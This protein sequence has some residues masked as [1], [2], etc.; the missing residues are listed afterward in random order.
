MFG[1]ISQKWP[2]KKV[3]D[4]KNQR[5]NWGWIFFFLPWDFPR[6]GRKGAENS[7]VAFTFSLKNEFK[8]TV[9]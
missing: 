5:P 8:G 4:V 9:S 3:S 7:F 2:S 6:K 1:R